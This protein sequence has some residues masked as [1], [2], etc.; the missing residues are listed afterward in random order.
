MAFNGERKEEK[1]VIYWQENKELRN[2][3]DKDKVTELLFASNAKWGR[4]DY[5]LRTLHMYTVPFLHPS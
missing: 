2:M 4:V 5:T 3:Q 1:V